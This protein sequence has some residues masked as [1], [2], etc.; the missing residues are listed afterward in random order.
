MKYPKNAVKVTE[1]DFWISCPHCEMQMEMIEREEK[2][3]GKDTE[4]VPSHYC[5][6]DDGTLDEDSEEHTMY[7]LE[8]NFW[9]KY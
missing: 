7:I 3:Y 4:Y 2:P 5:L 6:E 8:N 9:I 1:E